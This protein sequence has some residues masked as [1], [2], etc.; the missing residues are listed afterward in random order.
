MSELG[1]KA[2]P[3]IPS[4]NDLVAGPSPTTKRNAQVSNYAKFYGTYSGADIK[5]V[6]HY[7]HDPVI[8]KALQV[9]KSRTELELAEEEAYFW[10]NRGDFNTAALAHQTKLIQAIRGEIEDLD[11]QIAKAKNVPTSKTLGE[12]QTISVGSYRDKSP[13][14]P[15]GSVYPKGY[16]RG[17]RTI[18]GTMVFTIF[19]EHVLH[20]LMQLNLRQYS[21]G[22]SDY[23]RHLYTTMLI[24]QLPPLDISFIF[25]NE[26]GAISHMALYGVEFFQEGMTFSIEDIYSEST[27]QY[28]ARDFD[29]MRIVDRREIDGQGVSKTWTNTA[30]DMLREK[31]IVAHRIRRDPFI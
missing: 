14:R 15:L 27:I 23:D 30:S 7:P 19:H 11:S 10:A 29:P 24:D 1:T 25:A 18:S 21:T 12:L 22:S 31:Q 9:V 13:V 16:V 2:G 5:V 3:I 26:Y 4:K 8:E 17:P 28:V 20:E 6:V